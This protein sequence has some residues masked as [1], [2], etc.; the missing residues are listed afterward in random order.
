MIVP[1]FIPS[2]AVMEGICRLLSSICEGSSSFCVVTL[3][4]LS[5]SSIAS[6]KFDLPC[7]IQSSVSLYYN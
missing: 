1:L 5:I 2:V 6:L 3:R 4:I 7:Y